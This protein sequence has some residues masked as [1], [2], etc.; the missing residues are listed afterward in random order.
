MI[1]IIVCFVA[2]GVVSYF[3][4]VVKGKQIDAEVLSEL[5]KAEKSTNTK[6][7]AFAIW[8]KGKL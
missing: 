1:G 5:A 2:V 8:M 7:R 3:A 4:G 6:L